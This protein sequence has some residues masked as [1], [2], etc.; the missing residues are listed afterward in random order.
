MRKCLRPGKGVTNARKRDRRSRGR[1]AVESPKPEP[2]CSRDKDSVLAGGGGGGAK[3]KVSG[4]GTLKGERGFTV[5]SGST[6]WLEGG[7]E[8]G[9]AFGGGG[10]IKNKGEENTP[11][12]KKTN[13]GK[14]SF[15]NNLSPKKTSNF[16]LR[17]E[18]RE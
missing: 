10:S 14:H 3:L 11:R 6:V 12:M 7:T 8:R 4:T 15:R 18:G 13:Q 9:N 17:M 2:V 16:E 1:K 5:S